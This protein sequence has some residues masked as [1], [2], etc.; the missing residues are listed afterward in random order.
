MKPIFS[1]MAM[2]SLILLLIVRNNLVSAQIKNDPPD[3]SFVRWAKTNAYSLGN[4]DFKPIENM[5]AKTRVVALGEPEHGTNEAPDLRNRMFRYLVENSGFTAIVLEADFAKARIAAD[6]INGGPG[7]IEQAAKALSWGKPSAENIELIRW[8]RE[9]NQQP[10]HKIKIRLYGMDMEMIGVP[11]DTAS[12]HP[13]IDETFAYLRKIDGKTAEHFSG[14]LAPFLDRLSSANYPKFSNREHELL[15]L[16]LDAL[17]DTLGQKRL[18]Y[19]KA[20][21]KPAYDWAYQNAIVA[22]QTDHMVRLLPP[23]IPGKIPPDGWRAASD[24]D[25]A[26]AENVIWILQRESKILIYAHDAHVKNAVTKGGVWDVFQQAPKATGQY[27]RHALGDKIVIFGISFAPTFDIK[28]PSSLENVLIQTGK[29][30]FLINFRAADLDPKVVEW[31]ATQRPM[32]MN[33]VTYMNLTIGSAFDGIIY[34]EKK[35]QS[36]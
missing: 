36:Q 9:Y 29:S 17:I 5:A 2:L 22:R 25:S 12:S 35:H 32:Q 28:Q 15:S 34:L 10:A 14:V 26:M 6:Y 27:L 30:N 7:S 18:T 11:G 3:S 23:D 16:S 13:S 1:S 4:S 21:S 19:I 24:R 33:N 8:M 20:S 31:L